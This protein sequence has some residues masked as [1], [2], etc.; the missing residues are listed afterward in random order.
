MTNDYTEQI[1]SLLSGKLAIQ[2]VSEE[3][4]QTMLDEHPYSPYGH[5]V[6][7]LKAKSQNRGDAQEL[8]HRLATYSPDRSWLQHV[9]NTTFKDIAE[10]PKEDVAIPSEAKDHNLDKVIFE[11]DFNQP[12]EISQLP[13]AQDSEEST[14]EVSETE[15]LT[16]REEETKEQTATEPD[17][18]VAWLNSLK[19][20]DRKD[21]INEKPEPIKEGIRS[22]REQPRVIEKTTRKD[23][24]LFGGIL[25]ET[26]AELLASQ[27]ATEKAISMYERL[28]LIFPNKSAFFAAK[29]DQL[30]SNLTS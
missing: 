12:K 20:A 11:F 15:T 29:I 3:V 7:Y 1:A 9:L 14:P 22:K 16:I 6:N 25:T 28:S 30:K 27:G 24:D 10:L 18:Y 2:N 13:D 21:S 23:N 26:L 17:S 4:I 8:L 19:S 5:L